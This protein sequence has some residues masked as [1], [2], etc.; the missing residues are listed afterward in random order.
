V[1]FRRCSKT[2]RKFKDLIPTLCANRVITRC[3]KLAPVSA[4][5]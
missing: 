4:A 2:G 3:S 5:L 1:H